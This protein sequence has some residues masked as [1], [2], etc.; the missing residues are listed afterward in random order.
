MPKRDEQL[1]SLCKLLPIETCRRHGF[2]YLLPNHCPGCEQEKFSRDAAAATRGRDKCLTEA[3][4]GAIKL[5]AVLA[6]PIPAEP[7]ESLQ[8]R[9]RTDRVFAGVRL[10]LYG[11]TAGILVAAWLFHFVAGRFAP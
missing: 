11:F 9:K 8:D 3:E 10:F 1:Q 4:R 7:R 2:E 6:P 5:A